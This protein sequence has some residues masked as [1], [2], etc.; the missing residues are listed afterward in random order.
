LN[1]LLNHP[2]EQLS[3]RSRGPSVEP[4]RELVKVVVEMLVAYRTVQGAC[5]PCFQEPHNM[6][7]AWNAKLSG[8]FDVV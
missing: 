8:I 7:Y 6:M 5:Q 2:V 1:G 4:K 3:A